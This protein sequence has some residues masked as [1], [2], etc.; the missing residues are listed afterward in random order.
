MIRRLACA[1]VLTIA[2]QRPQPTPETSTAPVTTVAKGPVQEGKALLDQGQ[3]DAAITR[4][5]Q[6]SSNADA[7]Y[8]QGVAW[9][10]KAETAPLPTPVPAPPEARHLTA[11]RVPEFKPEELSALEMFAKAV[12][13]QPNHAPAHFATA[14]LLAMHS[15]RR[16]ELGAIA[17]RRPA[18]G[19]APAE[20]APAEGEPDYSPEKV[21]SEYR[22]AIQADP[23]SK[24]M[25]EALVRFAVRVGRLEDA[26]AGY[27]EL[28][29]RDKE[30]PEPLVRYG[31]F[32]VSQ[33]HDRQGAIESYRQALIWRP[34]DDTTRSKLADIYITMGIEAFA[35][36][37]YATA[38]ARFQDA[39][40]YVTDKNSPQGLK[41]QD[42]QARLREIRRP[43]G[44]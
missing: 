19:K 35:R 1:C 21:L 17:T 33:M 39:E 9:T 37:E 30:N 24:P 40:K 13:L 38:E 41:I 36:R 32:L 27:D 11:S 26:K 5:Q 4:L 20:P 23:T 44:R 7:A 31:D 12:S 2:C 18:H 6:A 28:V 42:H 10:R 29:H 25:V 22:A 8:Y 34:D 16:Y 14:E 15:A 43:T 3:F